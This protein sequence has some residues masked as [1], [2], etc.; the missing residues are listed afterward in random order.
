MAAHC[1]GWT[2]PRRKAGS[3]SIL[4]VASWPTP[5]LL[6]R[7]P[8]LFLIEPFLN[9]VF[10]WSAFPARPIKCCSVGYQCN[11]SIQRVFAISYLVP[12][13][14]CFYDDHAMAGCLLAG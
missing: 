2:C 14:L 10:C 3:S 6:D 5:E 11:E 4:A 13:P 7:A 9:G 8:L 1:S 12:V